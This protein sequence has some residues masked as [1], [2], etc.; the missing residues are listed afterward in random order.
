MSLILFESRYSLNAVSLAKLVFQNSRDAPMSPMLLC[1]R[2]KFKLVSFF[3]KKALMLLILLCY[4]YRVN[5]VRLVFWK[6]QNS[7]D[8]PMSLILLCCRVSTNVVS[9]V[10]EN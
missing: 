8:A 6:I 3:R 5:V 4:R 1:C 10:L 2:T 9:L 7:R